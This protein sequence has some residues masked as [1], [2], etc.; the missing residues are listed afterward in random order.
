MEGL[1][2]SFWVIAG[3][4]LAL[5]ATLAAMLLLS[6]GDAEDRKAASR[7][8]ALNAPD[9]I[10]ALVSRKSGRSAP[11]IPGIGD[12]VL[13]LHR[14]GVKTKPKAFFAGV[15]ALSLLIFALACAFINPLFA[16]VIGL[17]L[18]ALPPIAFLQ[19]RNRAY[20]TKFVQQLPDALDLMMRGLRVGHPVSVTIANVGK[21]MADPI[22]A[23]FR[24][25]ADQISHGD[26]LTDAFNDLADR[27]QQEDVDYLAVSI[28]IQHGTGGNLAEMLGTL[29]KVIR[30]RI[31]MRRRI[32]AISS[33]GR[34]SA[35]LLSCLPLLIFAATK[36]TAPNYY[37]DVAD[38]PL[39]KPA[40][41]AIAVLVVSNYLALRKLVTFNL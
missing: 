40:L 8:A 13:L 41:A 19:S 2:L 15:A 9:E 10:A 33:E 36:L 11:K 34:L 35:L 20:T 1:P 38:S 17:G 28:N 3:L 27:I 4:S 12:P 16:L 37:G 24:S 29:A 23:E 39:L 6:R 32:R 26:Y 18:G 31:M 21:T 14:A 7:V 22:G 30:D 25:L 5:F